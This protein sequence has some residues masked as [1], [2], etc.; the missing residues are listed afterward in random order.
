MNHSAPAQRLLFLPQL[1]TTTQREKK[2]EKSEV[3]NM[4]GRIWV[5]QISIWNDKPNRTRFRV[6]SRTTER[7]QKKLAFSRG[8]K[9]SVL[10]KS[11]TAN[12]IAWLSHCFRWIIIGRSKMCVPCS[13]YP[14]ISIAGYC[15]SHTVEYRE[16]DTVTCRQRR[17]RYH[18]LYQSQVTR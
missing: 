2:I 13:V 8:G 18:I 5:R 6:L 12:D 10:Y 15:T 4:P 17:W 16:N 14:G 1:T 3:L 9:S 11:T 7:K